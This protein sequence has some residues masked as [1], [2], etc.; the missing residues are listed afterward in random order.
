MNATGQSS[1]ALKV[2]K[3]PFWTAHGVLFSYGC[4]VALFSERPLDVAAIFGPLLSVFFG[5]SLL[6]VPYLI[7]MV[8][9]QNRVRAAN[10][11]AGQTLSFV[12]NRLEQALER[13]NAI[14]AESAKAIQSAQQVQ[15]LVD[16]KLV[17]LRDTLAER[18][19][20]EIASLRE[21]VELLRAEAGS[22]REISS[23]QISALSRGLSQLPP[24]LSEMLPLLKALDKHQQDLNLRQ[25]GLAGNIRALEEKIDSL[26][27]PQVA[28]SIPYDEISQLRA[29]VEKILTTLEGAHLRPVATPA[30]P[31][32]F[33]EPE[34]DHSFPLHEEPPPTTFSATVLPTETTV[35]PDEDAMDAAVADFA[36]ESIPPPAPVAAQPT[37]FNDPDPAPS[38]TATLQIEALIGVTNQLYLRGDGPGLSW[39]KGL[40]LEITGIGRWQWKCEGLTEPVKIHVYRND[41]DPAEGGPVTLKPGKTQILRPVFPKD[42]PRPQW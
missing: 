40:P 11:Q 17:V 25:T 5:G 28:S 8:D 19:S 12:V 16:E 35:S 36:D 18:E 30:E 2:P 32:I 34:D 41:K 33:S 1:P 26:S 6:A 29:L 31:S 39:D 22:L 20:S 14:E 7:E 10:A 21:E 24:N 27:I 42:A 23:E 9:R 38:S 13:L 4:Y 3:W 37:L 15:V